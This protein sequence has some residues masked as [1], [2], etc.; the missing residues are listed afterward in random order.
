MFMH[1][2]NRL[3][4]HQDSVDAIA[5]AAEN[6]EVYASERDAGDHLWFIGEAAEPVCHLAATMLSTNGE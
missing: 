6:R 4:V 3:S 1:D 2:R 5:V